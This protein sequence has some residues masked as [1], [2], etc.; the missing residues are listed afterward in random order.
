MKRLFAL[1]VLAPTSALAHGGHAALAEP[2]HGTFHA[3]PLIG[4]FALIAVVLVIW[5]ARE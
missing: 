4:A 3:A 5:R 1:A 2:A